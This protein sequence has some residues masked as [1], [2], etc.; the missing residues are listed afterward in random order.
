[1]AA[2]AVKFIGQRINASDS[3]TNWA[4]W[5][6]GGPSPAA[7]AQLAYQGGLA[8]NRKVT[9]T[10]GTRNGV[11]YNPGTGAVNM[12]LKNNRLWF[13]KAIVADSFDLQTAFGT[14]I[15]V[16]SSSSQYH[17]YV[18]SGTNA[19]NSR[20]NQWPVQGG[21]LITAIDPLVPFWRESTTG[22][23]SL[24]AVDYFAFGAAFVNGAAKAENVALDAIDI[25]E[26]LNL[27]RGDGA[28]ADGTFVN[29]V[30]TDQDNSSNRWGVVVGSGSNVR[31]HGMLFIGD[32][33]GSNTTSFTD[34]TSV[35]NFPNGYHS[36]NSV[37]ITIWN[38]NASDAYVIDSL[39]IS[40]GQANVSSYA[41]SDTRA[42]F[43]VQGSAGS[44]VFGGTIRNFKRVKFNSSVI[45]NNAT[46]FCE[47][48]QANGSSIKNCTLQTNAASNFATISDYPHDNVTDISDCDFVQFGSGHALELSVTDNTYNFTN[49][50]FTDYNSAN[51]FSDSAIYVSATTG[52]T[53]INLIGTNEPSVRTAGAT[54]TFVSSVSVEL[55][56]MKDFTEVRVYNSAG[57]QI[58]GVEDIGSP[59]NPAGAGIENGSVGGTTNDRSFTFS[60]TV[61]NDLTFRIININFVQNA[62]W[63]ADDVEYTTTA[64]STQSIPIAQR[65]DRVFSNP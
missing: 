9:A 49:L 53:T 50:T 6:G 24:N 33:V 12:T 8:V 45:A 3:A 20:Y 54:V 2:V 64:A 17:S 41:N 57:D 16:G 36:S 46:I 1:M 39:L 65:Q 14:E 30:T 19:N 48:L 51:A 11:Q 4:N 58:A 42:D 59:D 28:D 63:I 40:A 21:Y 10:G 52:T 25:G 34:T 56:G 29:F 22:S 27:Q 44:L 47:L 37:G 60:T 26:G 13:V 18:S 43:N 5:N 62:Y 7:E 31:A 38:G 15:L 61:G 55:T 23:V 32:D 35:V